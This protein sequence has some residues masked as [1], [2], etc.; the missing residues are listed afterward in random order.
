MEYIRIEESLSLNPGFAWV[1]IGERQQ[2]TC[3]WPTAW[4]YLYRDELNRLMNDHASR[5]ANNHD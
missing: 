1:D 2:G 4:A 3:Q 5:S